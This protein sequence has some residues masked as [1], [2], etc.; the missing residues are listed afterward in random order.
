MNNLVYLSPNT[1]E[2]FTTSEVIANCVGVHH[3]TV[4]RLIQQHE[5]DFKE[6]GILRFQIEEIRGRGQPKKTYHLNEQQAT[7]LMTYLRN[8]PVVREFKKE[9]VRQFFAMREELQAVREVKAERR[10]IRTGMLDAIKA[11]PESPHKHFKYAQFSNLAYTTA[12]GKSARM[13]REER[14]A[15]NKTPASDYLT[16]DEIAAVTAME[17]RIAVLL[18]IGMTYQQVKESLT[19]VQAPPKKTTTYIQEGNDTDAY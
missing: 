9:L 10:E 14:G 13:I 5:K 7:L 8:T 6:F 12:L 19:H 11:L 17:N 15:N 3:H 18:E 2:P 1:K 16:A 4:T